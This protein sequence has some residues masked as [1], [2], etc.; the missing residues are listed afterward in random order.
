LSQRAAK[1]QS[2]RRIVIDGIELGNRG[3]IDRVDPYLIESADTG[4]AEHE[5][6][7]HDDRADGHQSHQTRDEERDMGSNLPITGLQPF[8][9]MRFLLL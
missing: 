5:I 8:Q 4:A 6:W 1:D 2:A 7:V 3:V 9:P